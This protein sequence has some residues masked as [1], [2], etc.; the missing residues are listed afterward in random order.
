MELGQLGHGEVRVETRKL[1]VLLGNKVL[2]RSL[3]RLGG[4]SSVSTLPVT[5]FFF[6]FRW[7]RLGTYLI[8]SAWLQR[9]VVP[10]L[11]TGHVLQG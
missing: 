3:L 9:L 4:C 6:V 2:V 10:G 11:G 5:F 7:R 1:G 8:G